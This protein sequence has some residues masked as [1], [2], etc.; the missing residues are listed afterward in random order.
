MRSST[1]PAREEDG[2]KRMENAPYDGRGL[3]PNGRQFGWILLFALAVCIIA[4]II[5]GDA[6][7]GLIYGFFAFLGGLF[8]WCRWREILPKDG[9]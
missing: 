3:H 6:L 5:K 2:S 1:W 9:K 7:Y 4:T 8:V